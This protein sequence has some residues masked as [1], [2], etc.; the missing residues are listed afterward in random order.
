[1]I[2]RAFVLA[3]SAALALCGCVSTKVLGDNQPGEGDGGGPLPAFDALDLLLVID[4]TAGGPNPME[5]A[6]L[7]PTMVRALQSGDTNNDGEAEFRGAQ[8]L[9]V[10]V[11]TTDMGAPGITG[12]PDCGNDTGKPF[13]DDGLFFTGQPGLFV[14]GHVC[15]TQ[16]A[17]LGLNL[18][19]SEELRTQF[20]EALSCS[21]MVPVGGCGYRMPLEAALKA[22]WDRDDANLTFL[23]GKGHGLSQQAGF[24]REGALLAIVVITN[25]DDCSSA[26]VTHLTPAES[27]DPSDPMA[28]VGRGSRCVRYED[29]LHPIWR[30][31][32]AYARLKRGVVS[33]VF[34]GVIGGIPS[35]FA[36]DLRDQRIDVARMQTYKHLL[37][38]PR[39]QNVPNPDGPP[40][41]GRLMPVCGDA[42][43]SR[44]LVELSR[45]FEEFSTAASIC[46]PMEVSL[47]TMTKAIARL[48]DPSTSL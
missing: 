1:M 3:L 43:P 29:H 4:N 27:L 22:T 19:A 30:Y 48:V 10:A 6:A 18:P 21:A 5:V 17:P 13:G 15:A 32:E 26:D 40:G 31:E 20:D 45:R 8:R 47:G 41:E 9:Q 7:L 11:V 24:V 12:L 36:A 34:F 25:G 33:D 2:L 38:D 14:E 42:T 28:N 46:D 37:D 35:D 44:R 23:G 39:M 16:P